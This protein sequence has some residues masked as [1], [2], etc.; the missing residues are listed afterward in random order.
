MGKVMGWLAPKTRGR[1][2]GRLV[3]QA[4]TRALAGVSGTDGTRNAGDTS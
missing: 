2:D 3:S 1:A 4:V